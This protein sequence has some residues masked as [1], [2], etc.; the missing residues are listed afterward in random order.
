MIKFCKYCSLGHHDSRIFL[1]GE[2][3]LGRALLLGEIQYVGKAASSLAKML[4]VLLVIETP[5]VCI[6]QP[7]LRIFLALFLQIYPYLEG[8]EY[9]RTSDWVND[10]LV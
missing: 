4:F 3:L 7:F 6:W 1:E 2:L 10:F 8:F 5:V 9:N